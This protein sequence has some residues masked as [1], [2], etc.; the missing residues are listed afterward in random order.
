MHYDALCNTKSIIRTETKIRLVNHDRGK[1]LRALAHQRQELRRS[2]FL[3]LL[4]TQNGE[5]WPF[6][7]PWPSTAKQAKNASAVPIPTHGFEIS[8]FG[9]PLPPTPGTR[10]AFGRPSST[11]KR[12]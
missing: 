2:S 8:S 10:A 9:A 4:L 5:T 7:T 6:L 11:R 12:S 3:I 1:S